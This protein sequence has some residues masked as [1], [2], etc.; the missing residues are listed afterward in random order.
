MIRS[1][2]L[3]ANALLPGPELA[4]RPADMPDVTR[5]AARWWQDRAAVNGG[6]TIVRRTVTTGLAA[7]PAALA[8][9]SWQ[10]RPGR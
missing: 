5:P 2:S 8:G 3:A 1:T 7:V 6:A 4:E 9:A 10:M